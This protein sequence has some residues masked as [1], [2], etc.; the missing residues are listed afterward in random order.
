[1]Q[2]QLLENIMLRLGSSCFPCNATENLESMDIQNS[3]PLK[4]SD[5]KSK[6][7]LLTSS[8]S[9]KTAFSMELHLGSYM[10]L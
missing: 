3:H 6:I 10:V 7:F 5:W 9:S 1:M 4:P 2:T 8:K